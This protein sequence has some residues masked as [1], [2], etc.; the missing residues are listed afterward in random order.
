M[1]ITFFRHST[2]ISI[3]Q[4]IVIAC[5]LLLQGDRFVYARKQNRNSPHHHSGVLESYSPGPFTDL[6]LDNNDEKTLM[7]GKA[8][9]KVLADTEDP[10]GG[11]KSICVQDIEAPKTAVWNQILDLDHYVGKV[12]KVKE[13]KNY[14]L[15]MKPDGSFKVKTKMVIGVMPGYKYEYYCDHTYHPDQDSVVWSLDYDKVSDFDDV[16]GHWHVEDHPKKPGCSR[17]FYACDIKFKAALPK[18]VLNFLTKSALKSATSWVKRESE[19]SPDS[20]IPSEFQF[21]YAK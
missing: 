15:K 14:L 16:A 7:G 3:L 17:V 5:L 8:V 20:P 10:S 2:S 13:C 19:A 21:E 18:P 12:S 1:F 9:M 11:G 4:C 6:S